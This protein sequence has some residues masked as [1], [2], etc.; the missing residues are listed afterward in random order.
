M[1]PDTPIREPDQIRRDC[2]RKLQP[3]QVSDHFQAILGCLFT[4]AWTTPRLIEMVITPDGHLLGRCEGEAPFKPSW[5]NL[6]NSSYTDQEICVSCEHI[7]ESYQRPLLRR[8]L[9]PNWRTRFLLGLVP[10][11]RA[12]IL[13]LLRFDREQCSSG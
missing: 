1:T 3:V 11:Q 7:G 12:G 9:S 5:V 6:K 13:Y 2:D 10:P 8:L 4:E